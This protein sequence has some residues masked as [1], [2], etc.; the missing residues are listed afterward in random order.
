MLTEIRSALEQTYP[1]REVVV[2]DDGSRDRNLE[3]IRTFGDAI[4]REIGPNQGGCAA[5]N[6]DA[7][8]ARSSSN[9]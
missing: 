2:I 6:W 3:V 1:S 4:R 7:I 9:L 5:R 8:T